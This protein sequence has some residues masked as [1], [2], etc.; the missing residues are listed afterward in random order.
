MNGLDPES[1]REIRGVIQKLN[2]EKDMTISSHILG[3]LSKVI[4]RYRIIRSGKMIEDSIAKRLGDR[5]QA[6]RHR[7]II[8]INTKNNR[9]H[10]KE[11]DV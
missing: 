11:R 7:L 8:Q 5:E 2:E 6:R 3:E 9:I 1:I 4:T 10:F